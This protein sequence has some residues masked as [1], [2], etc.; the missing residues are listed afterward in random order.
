MSEPQ[1]PRR[2]PSGLTMFEVGIILLLVV[3]GGWFIWGR[4]QTAQETS[5]RASA[6][7]Q[8]EELG[9]QYSTAEEFELMFG[10]DHTAY[11]GPAIIA[12]DA[13]PLSRKA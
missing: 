2:R 1:E 3:A 10:V 13:K 6:K 7:A 11:S 8:L 9:I 5:V 12:V 4:M